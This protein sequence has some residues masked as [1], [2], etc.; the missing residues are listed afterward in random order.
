MLDIR[1]LVSRSIKTTVDIY[2]RVQLSPFLPIP[3]RMLRHR[4]QYAG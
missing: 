1:Y 2:S 3:A 4:L